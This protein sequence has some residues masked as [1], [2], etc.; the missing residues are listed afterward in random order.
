MFNIAKITLKNE[1]GG[2]KTNKLHTSVINSCCTFS[3]RSLCTCA[4]CH[5]KTAG[6]NYRKRLVSQKKVT[7]SSAWELKKLTKIIFYAHLPRRRLMEKVSIK[8]GEG[9]VALSWV[10]PESSQITPW[11][12][13]YGKEDLLSTT[14]VIKC[15]RVTKPVKPT[16]GCS[17]YPLGASSAFNISPFN[18][19]LAT[20]EWWTRTLLASFWQLFRLYL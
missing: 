15:C 3:F 9:K 11:L 13:L 12:L 1:N 5:K 2:R 4:S 8:A 6:I 10:I 17:T 20:G 16:I 7:P 18:G 14:S 19:E